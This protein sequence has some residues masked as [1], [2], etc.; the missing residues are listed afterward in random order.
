MKVCSKCGISKPATPECFSRSVGEN[1]RPECKACQSEY[2]Q[3]Y[4]KQNQ[5]ALNAAAAEYRANN[6]ESLAEKSASY[7]AALPSDV[8]RAR[9]RA[10]ALLH[11]YGM[12]VEQYDAILTAQGGVCA[13]CR[14]PPKSKL[15]AVDHDHHTGVVRG[16]LCVSCNT[17]LGRLGDNEAGLLRVLEYVRHGSSLEILTGQ[18]A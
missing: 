13:L 16:L 12:T 3:A 5:A 4:G 1:L 14:R 7:Y 17:S 2:R 6:R 18:T 11:E 9:N 15:L 10:Y 8:V